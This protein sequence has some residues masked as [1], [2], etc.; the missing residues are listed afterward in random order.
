MTEPVTWSEVFRVI[1][2][3]VGAG[4]LAGLFLFQTI[5][6]VRLALWLTSGSA[7]HQDREG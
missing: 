5:I 3:V 6:F 7:S 2:M 1:L 4:T